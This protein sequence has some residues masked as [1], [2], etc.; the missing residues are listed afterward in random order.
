MVWPDSC[1]KRNKENGIA[2]IIARSRFDL[3]I[4]YP[5]VIAV[6]DHESC[7]ATIDAGVLAGDDDSFVLKHKKASFFVE[8]IIARKDRKSCNLGYRKTPAITGGSLIFAI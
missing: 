1:G 6:A 7:L 8:T 5:A 2:F 3:C 4:Q